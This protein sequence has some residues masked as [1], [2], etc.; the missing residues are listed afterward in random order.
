[1]YLAERPC[2]QPIARLHITQHAA[3]VVPRQNEKATPRRWANRRGVKCRSRRAGPGG[4]NGGDKLRRSLVYFFATN[5]LPISAS[6]SFTLPSLVS[7]TSAVP[8][9]AIH[10]RWLPRRYTSFICG[11]SSRMRK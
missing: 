4:L 6:S 11:C 1:L 2:E 5:S 8:F 7:T 9:G 3:Q 10:T